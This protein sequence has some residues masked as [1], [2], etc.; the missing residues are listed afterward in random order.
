MYKFLDDIYFCQ[1][2]YLFTFLINFANAKSKLN[3]QNMYLAYVV[4]VCKKE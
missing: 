1:I 3:S 4:S 2:D